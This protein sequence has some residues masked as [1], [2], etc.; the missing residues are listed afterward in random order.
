LKSEG[1]YEEKTGEREGR[2]EQECI[3]RKRVG[4]GGVTGAVKGEK[5]GGARSIRAGGGGWRRSGE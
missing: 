2:G 4:R 3:V 5:R 1:A